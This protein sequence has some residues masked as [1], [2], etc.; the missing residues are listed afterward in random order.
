MAIFVL[1]VIWF[2]LTI[3]NILVALFLAYIFMAA[4]SPLV[5]Q[6]Q[7][8]KF[9]KILAVSVAFV[10]TFSLV[11]LIIFPLVPFFIS[12]IQSLY[13]GFP[14]YLDTVVKLIGFNIS[15]SQL[16]SI[17][18]AEIGS[19]GQNAILVT[20]K[21]FNGLFSVL[22]VMVV[23]FYLM[24]DHQRVKKSITGIFPEKSQARAYETLLK[25]EYKLGAWFRGQIVLCVFIGFFTWIILTLLGVPF[26]LPL[27][28][29]AGLLEVIPTLGPIISAIPA[30]I[31]SIA[32]APH[33]TIFVILAYILIQAVENNFLVPKIMQKAV[34]LNPI[35]VIIGIIVGGEL[36]G[37]IGALLSIPFISMLVI[38]YSAFQEDAS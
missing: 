12:Q 21:V 2:L 31:V 38:I 32:V 1:G 35:V 14:V 11:L 9:P 20:G 19:I 8:W 6:L 26:A 25:I 28:L 10:S 5:E 29:I 15:A 30:V 17:A 4:L 13:I 34:G 18:K 22:T 37:L 27:A 16:D 3:Q 24:L 36:M 33:L 23:S 7:R